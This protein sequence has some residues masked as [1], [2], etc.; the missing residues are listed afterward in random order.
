MVEGVTPAPALLRIVPPPNG[1]ANSDEAAPGRDAGSATPLSASAPAAPASVAAAAESGVPR[2][3]YPAP[4]PVPTQEGPRGIRFDFSDGANRA[5]II[6]MPG[7]AGEL[8]DK[9]TILAIKEK[10]ITEPSKLANVH[11]E[12]AL[13]QKLKAEC[14]PRGAELALLESELRSVNG[15]LWDVEDALR[16]HEARLDFGPAF[17]ELARQVYKTNDRRAALKREINSLCN[18]AIVEEKSYVAE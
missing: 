16:A 6:R 4:A 13:L 12:L 2:L 18:S 7:S 14:V 17:I 9:I 3:A 1:A 8:I 5:A 15:S 11:R 10:R